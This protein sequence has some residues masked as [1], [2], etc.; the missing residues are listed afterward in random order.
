MKSIGKDVETIQSYH[1]KGP[2]LAKNWWMIP[3]VAMF[4]LPAPCWSQFKEPVLTEIT[5]DWAFEWAPTLSSDMLE[6]YWQADEI[7]GDG[8][9]WDIWWTSRESIDAPWQDPQLLDVVNTGGVESTPHLS[10][11]GLTLTFASSGR[12]G[13]YGGLDLWQTFRASRDDPWQ[14]PVNMGPTINTRRNEGS[15]AFSADGLEIIFNGGCPGGPCGPTR[16]RRSTRKTLAD[17]WTTPEEMMPSK[18]GDQLRPLTYP[19]LSPDGL[20]L[21]YDR[22]GVH[23]NHD[24]FVSKRPSLDALFGEGENLGATINSSGKDLGARIAA[25]GS[26]YYTYNNSGRARIWR[27]EAETPPNLSFLNAGDADQDLDFDQLDLVQVQVAAKYLTVEPATWGEGD[28]DGAPGGTLGSPPVGNGLFD[29]L[30]VIAALAAGTYLTGPYAAIQPN[31]QIGDG[32]TSVVYSPAT[33]EF[34]VDAPEGVELTSINI[35]SA[36]GIFT[37]NEAANLG[38]SFDNDA[39]GNIFKATFGSSFGS[40]SFGNV[41]R[42][43]LSEEFVLGDLSVVGSLTGGGDLGNVDLVY[44]PEP[45]SACLLAIGQAVALSHLRRK[46]RRVKE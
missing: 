11:D 46:T 8:S 36:A 37:G 25:D 9:F 1:R 34:S 29:Q 13:G 10:H 6:V 33:G 12:A 38:G 18:R 26:L 17:E 15:A 44:V 19:S 32:Q 31:G 21:Y 20:S 23:G 40:L 16:P 28:W 7:A 2:H 30:D 27:A 3:V 22:P 5:T 45:A 42:P 39:D 4:G 14:E 43:G 41:L 35:D 24:I